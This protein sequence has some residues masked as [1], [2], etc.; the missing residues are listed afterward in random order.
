MFDKII[1]SSLEK[2]AMVAPKGPV[3]LHSCN[4]HI[5]RNQ[6]ETALLGWGGGGGREWEWALQDTHVMV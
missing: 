3:P 4:R 1:T 6:R 5:W 2:S